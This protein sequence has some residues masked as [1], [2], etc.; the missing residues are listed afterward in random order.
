MQDSVSD[1]EGSL[2]ALTHIL[3]QLDGDDTPP[4]RP[5]LPTRREAGRLIAGFSHVL[6]PDHFPPPAEAAACSAGRLW[7]LGQAVWDLAFVIHRVHPHDCPPDDLCPV[8]AQSLHQAETFAADLPTLQALLEADAEAAVDGD[9]AARHTD[10]V[11]ATYPGFFATMV[12]R[13]AHRLLQLGIPFLPRLLTEWAHGA[14]GIDIHPGAEIGP[15]FF[16]DHGTG[17]V[18]GETTVIGSDV[19]LYQGVTLG[20][21]NFPRD[22]DGRIIRGQKRH[23]TIEDRVVIYAEATILGGHTVVGHDSEIGGNVWL[24]KSVPPYS[25]VIAPARVERVDKAE[26]S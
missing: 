19:T 11:I 23:P 25:K 13:L 5:A 26:R 8:L 18:I 10:E 21:L 3:R 15:R 16:I 7:Q 1:L 4:S 14:T 22:A 2:K 9:P 6:F 17:V 24:T 20:A 12:Y